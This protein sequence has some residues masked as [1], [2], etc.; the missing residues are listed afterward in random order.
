MWTSKVNDWA[1]FVTAQNRYSV[2]TRDAE[3]ELIPAAQ[4]HDVALLPYFPL[5]SGLLSGKYT[6]GE[7]AP[8]GTRLAT[9]G[10]FADDAKMA[11][12]ELIEAA[13]PDIPIL[14]IA[15]GWLA[16]QPSVVSVIAGAT[17]PEHVT[18]NARAAAW[19]PTDEQIAAIDAITR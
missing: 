19:R 16:A 18:A 6:R 15:M 12:V 8:E 14:D 13:I 2:L 10:G 4:H 17:K 1:P 3:R 7:R 9:W 5:E 11:Q